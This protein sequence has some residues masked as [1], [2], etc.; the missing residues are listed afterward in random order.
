MSSDSDSDKRDDHDQHS[1]R[2]AETL[3]RIGFAVALIAWF[4]FLIYIADDPGPVCGT[5]Q[6]KGPC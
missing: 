3:W 4:C 5:G 6:D 2:R 1:R